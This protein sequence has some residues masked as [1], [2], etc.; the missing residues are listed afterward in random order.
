M[1]PATEAPRASAEWGWRAGP[2]LGLMLLAVAGAK[3]NMPERFIDRFLDWGLQ[4]GL[5]PVTGVIE[6]LLGTGLLVAAS[7]AY[8]AAGLS[9][10]MLGA[11]TVHLV[12]GDAHLS[13]V[14]LGIAGVAG[15]VLWS[16]VP[17]GLYR[18]Q[19]LP[20]PLARPPQ[21]VVPRALFLLRLLGVSFFFRWIVGGLVYWA[22]LPLL[23]ALHARATAHPGSRRLLESVLLYLLVLGIGVS[24]VWGFVGHFFLSEQV[25][26]SIGWAAGSPFQLELAFY[27]LASGLVGLQCLWIRD[28]YWIAAGSIPALFALGAGLIHVQDFL[29]SG[30]DAS[31]NW[32]S[33]VLV[34]NFL[35]P[36]TLIVALGWFHRMG[37][38]RTGVGE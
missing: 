37:G 19:G 2:L 28:R 27:H 17:S 8:A 6:L 20:A 5:I 9:V 4:P 21:R 34:G 13:A 14:P 31:A 36:L 7:R 32:G 22:A 10:W 24:G 29:A 30:N 26:L 11:A 15:I 25:A 35:I 23:G 18:L 12:A 33:A 3:L 38:F 1:S 16:G